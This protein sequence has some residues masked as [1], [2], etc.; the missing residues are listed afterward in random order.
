MR[1]ATLAGALVLIGLAL[2]VTMAQ[3]RVSAT[4]PDLEATASETDR[5]MDMVDAPLY[6][7][8]DLDAFDKIETIGLDQSATEPYCD[9]K[10]NLVTTLDH[11][12]AE[13]RKAAQPLPKDR[14]I[15]LYA[16]DVMG[17][18]TAV[19]NRP[20]GVSCVINS[21]IDWERGNNPVALLETALPA[22]E[23]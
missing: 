10:A 16:S 21:G 3:S 19:Y 2:P 11:D 23:G 1:N 22:Q 15:E 13:K 8:G 12:F 20:D 18:W 9:I 14:E 7:N 4:E 6:A 17:T 5:P